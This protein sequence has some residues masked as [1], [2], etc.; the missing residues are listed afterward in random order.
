MV[1]RP[2]GGVAQR[3]SLAERLLRRARQSRILSRAVAGARSRL[4][5]RLRRLITETW[6]LPILMYHRVAPDGAPATARY[7]VTPEAFEQQLRALRRAG[8]RSVSLEEWRSAMASRHPLPGRAV[9]LTF[10]DGYRDFLTHA[11]PLL[12]RYRFSAT[13]FLVADLIGQTNR[14]DQF[15]GEEVPLLGW[16]EI[17]HLQAEGVRFES[18]SATH[19]PMTALSAA[20]VVREASHARDTLQRG[21]GKPVTAIAYPHGDTDPVVQHLV[22]RCGY[23]IGLS[24]TPG[25]SSFDDRSLCLPRIEITGYDTL[26]DYVS[27]L[28]G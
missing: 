1:S 15:Y 6:C 27:K 8:Y 3:R 5:G 4:P 7:R 23:S 14:W 28:H 24:C 2:R 22:G 9:L 18:H 25:R 19:P 16:E 20:E 10:D 17:R 21:L 26:S 12:R 13:V 11:W